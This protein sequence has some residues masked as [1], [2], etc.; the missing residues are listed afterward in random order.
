[1]KTKGVFLCL[2]GNGSLTIASVK[3]F[4]DYISLFGYNTLELGLDDMFAIEEEPYYGYL[5]GTYKVNELQELDAYAK[6]KGIELVPSAQFL[7][8]FDYLCK[9]PEYEPII[10]IDSILLIDEERTYQL[11]ENMFRTLRKCFSSNKINIAFDEAHRVGLGK[12]L[13]KHGYVNRFDLLLKHLN[14]V[15]E[16]AKKYDFHP[17]MWSDMFFKL[18]NKGIYYDKGV[19][20]S[21]DVINKIPEDMGLC[22]WDYY[23]DDVELLDSMFES[24]KELNREIYFA[25]SISTHMGFAP[26][27]KASLKMLSIQLNEAKKFNVEN[28]LVTLWSDDGNDCSTFTSLLGLYSASKMID[29]KDI[30][31]NEFKKLVGISYDEFMLLDLPNKSSV[32]PNLEEFNL[33]CKS[34]LFNDPF[35]GW[36]DY[37]LEKILPINYAS[38]VKTFDEVIP[39]INNDWKYQFIKLRELCNCLSY[40]Y[41]LGIKTRKAYAKKDKE[42]L[43]ELLPIYDE[44]KKSL[45][46]FREAF[47]QQWMKENKPHGWD[48]QEI[49]IGGLYFRLDECQKRLSSYIEGE[50][51]SI[52]ELEETLLRYAKFDS[53]FNSY[54]GWVTLRKI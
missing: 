54:Q 45:L 19:H 49:R 14:K 15:C 21:K 26:A 38:M 16:I 42:S 51:N 4:I 24:H 18:A 23:S 39:N 8:H 41:D 10:D 17:H 13:D 48:V 9:T 6:E 1:M 33:T 44:C 53:L 34:L 31:K 46:A 37:E 32:N 12:Y 36:K 50:L 30:D 7:G 20:F 5:R 47:H 29:G 2:S 3:K 28:Y 40:K 11:I 25:G 27:N 35:L 22:Y 43:K 52:P